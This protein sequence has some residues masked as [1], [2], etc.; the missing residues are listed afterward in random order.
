MISHASHSH[1]CSFSG[2]HLEG[3][4]FHLAQ[5]NWTDTSVKLLLGYVGGGI[6]QS[7]AAHTH[8][9]PVHTEQ[10]GTN[11]QHTALRPLH[12]VT[13]F[14]QCPLANLHYHTQWWSLIGTALS[15]IARDRA[16]P[17][18]SQQPPIF[19]E[20]PVMPHNNITK[21]KKGFV[22][23]W[24]NRIQQSFTGVSEEKD[25]IAVITHTKYR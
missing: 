8:G 23:F 13:C 9:Q 10:T 3:I 2:K 24:C 18:E 22:I 16:F 5:M 12:R 17:H 14:A 25:T 7:Q 1:Q 15:L 4:S 21:L 20:I 11:I 6:Q 19:Y